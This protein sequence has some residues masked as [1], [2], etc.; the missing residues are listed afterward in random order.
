MALYDTSEHRVY[1]D[2]EN[3]EFFKN[4]N[5]IRGR[6]NNANY[7]LLHINK[8]RH[9]GQMQYPFVYCPNGSGA[10][11]MS[12]LQMNM[13]KGYYIA[14][15]GGI[16][17]IDGQYDTTGGNRRNAPLGITIQNS[18]IVT[19]SD[20][21][22]F[23]ALTIDGSGNLGATAY[24][25]D[26]DPQTL[27]NNG[28]VSA[29]TGFGSIIENYVATANADSV[30]GNYD[31]QRQIIGQYANGDY[32]ILTIEGRNYD[33]STGQSVANILSFCISL[34]L[35]FAYLLDGGGS[36]ETVVGK[37]QLN[38]IYEGTY[39]RLVPTYLVFN[40]KSTFSVSNS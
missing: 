29:V 18:D 23:G 36:T 24:G 25:V 20:G 31:A 21:H 15:N 19:G 7:Y 3:D 37:K 10:R 28:I 16:F 40:G 8:L 32:A 9:D 5:I 13:Q 27:I 6:V 26:V 2:S 14:I 12:T 38:T 34:G 35:K 39:G 22:Y 17:D 1:D 4:T 30:I 11:T 33:N